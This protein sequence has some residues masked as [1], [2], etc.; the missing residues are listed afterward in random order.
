MDH[1]SFV[2][3]CQNISLLLAAALL[4]DVI[5]VRWRVGE[6]LL[7][8]A[9]VGVVLGTIGIMVML[10]PWTLMPGLVFDTRS[11]LIGISGLFFGTLATAVTVAM[12]AA[13]RVF[14]GGQGAGVGVSV[15]VVSGL[16]GIAWR[17]FKKQPLHLTSWREL[18]LLG[19]VIHVFMLGIMLTL[20]W[21]IATQVISNIAFPVLLIYPAGTALMG[22]LLVNRLKREHFRQELRQSEE[23]YR[24]IVETSLEGVWSLDKNFATTYVNPR[25]ADMLGYEQKDMLGRKFSHFIRQDQLSDQ[26]IRME[27]RKAGK[28]RVYECCFRKN[29]G[30]ELWAIISPRGMFDTQGQFVGSF[31]MLTD[32]T[33]R[34]QSEKA[35]LQ[36]KQTS[37]QKLR[38]PSNRQS[39]SCPL[40]I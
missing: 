35:L 12:T 38:F 16:I 39:P 23:R 10:T 19:L 13:F 33:E 25:M 8:Q 14:Q 37:L 36:A 26:D 4:F 31:A 3:I 32:I 24:Q 22:S 30:D 20:P 27:A 17:H 40:N 34:K 6:A 1:G 9:L 21:D 29:D 11:V 2:G 5:A 28:N 15:I 18:Y 7:T